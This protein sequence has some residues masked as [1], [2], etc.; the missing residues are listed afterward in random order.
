MTK[1]RKNEDVLPTVASEIAEL[2]QDIHDLDKSVV[3][4]MEQRKDERADFASAS[5]ANQAALEL[6]KA[7]LPT[8]RSKGCG[9][10]CRSQIATCI[11]GTEVEELAAEVGGSRR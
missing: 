9:C 1:S 7:P 11:N 3:Q 2:Q 8:L 5:V 4:G 10:M 6:Q